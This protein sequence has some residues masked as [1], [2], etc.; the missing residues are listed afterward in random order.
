[1][2]YLSGSV[3]RLFKKEVA[4]K[5]LTGS[6]ATS[7]QTDLVTEDDIA[8][9]PE[10]V[11]KYLR[12]AGVVGKNRVRNARFVFAGDFKM[13]PKQIW[14]RVR[15]EQYNFFDDL[16]RIVYIKGT[17]SGIPVVGRDLYAEGKGNMIIRAAG[18]CPVANAKGPAMDTSGWK[19]I[20]SLTASGILEHE[21]K[22]VSATL[23][24]NEKG[25]PVDFA[26]DDR[27]YS[28]TG[29]TSKRVRWSTPVRNY[30][31]FA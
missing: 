9:R 11:R 4:E 2:R 29:K 24:F 21:R 18:L 25:E 19:S 30:R 22:N 20:D 14:I 27:H 23:Q 8:P 10:P 15:T 31:D 13:S 17:I 6:P 7:S 12:R 5:F 1:M 26:T 28:P 16:T 3:N